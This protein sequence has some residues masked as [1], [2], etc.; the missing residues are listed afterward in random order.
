LHHSE[1]TSDTPDEEANILVLN[2]KFLLL[3]TGIIN[4]YEWTGFLV[5]VQLMKSDQSRSLLFVCDQI[6]SV[7]LSMQ[8]YYVL[9]A[10]VMISMIWTSVI[11][12]NRHTDRQ[13][14]STCTI[15]S[16]CA[17]YCKRGCTEHASLM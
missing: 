7:G 3:Y 6:S 8:D 14:L 10:V 1:N 4:F 15:S 2:T 11:L 9:Y 12:V 16:A 13:L 5:Q 17:E